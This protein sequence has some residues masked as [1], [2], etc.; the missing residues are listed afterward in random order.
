MQD[1]S[2]NCCGV[3][4]TCH[5]A[6]MFLMS[7]MKYAMDDFSYDVMTSCPKRMQISPIFPGFDRA[8][9]M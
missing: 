7:G 1:N 6:L 3:V 2:S 8:A 4:C 5:G 9:H